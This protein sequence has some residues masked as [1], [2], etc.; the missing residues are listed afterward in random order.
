MNDGGAEIGNKH[1][2]P[3]TKRKFGGD[4]FAQAIAK[5]AVAQICERV[6]FQTFQQS[7]LGTLSDIAVQ[8]IHHIGKTANFYANLAGRTKGNA[9]D[10][11]QGLEDLGPAQGFA[12]A[13]DIDHCLASSGVVR[14]IIK[15]VNEAQDSPFAYSIPCFPVVKEQNPTPSFFQIG[16]EPPDEHIPAW[17][18]AFPDPQTYIQFPTENERAPDTHM[19]KNEPAKQQRKVERS[20]LNMQQRFACNGQEGPSSVNHGDISKEK[21]S[22]ESNPF[23]S[24]PL[25][26]KEKEVS[27]MVRPAKLSKE[28]TVK[29]PAADARAVSNHISVVETF[30]PAIEAMKNKLYDSEEEQTKVLLNQRPAVQFKIGV[31]KNR[32][33]K[34]IQLDP[35]NQ[36]CNKIA[37]WFGKD[38]EKDEKRRRAEK[39]LKYST[40]NTQELAQM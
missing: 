36:D 11:L 22:A 14:E 29:H 8:Y 16:E 32:L 30:A 12:G 9:F 25:H 33:G 24:A 3:N 17:L 23:L 27:S 21:F 6:G 7:A 38:D 10:I 20:L 35:L 26:F 39:I 40:E 13:S 1:E 18:P 4:D 15:Y 5:I 2:H 37:P 34:P 28:V 31:G 19:K